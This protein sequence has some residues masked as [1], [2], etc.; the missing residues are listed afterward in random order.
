MGLQT[1]S[2]KANRQR[3]P[4]KTT[5]CDEERERGKEME[6]KL[7]MAQT[8]SNWNFSS[9]FSELS[10][11]L[12]KENEKRGVGSV[13]TWSFSAR[14]SNFCNVFMLKFR[15]LRVREWEKGCNL[16]LTFFYPL[17]Y[18]IKFN[19]TRACLNRLKWLFRRLKIERGGQGQRPEMS[20]F[21]SCYII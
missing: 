10:E 14:S 21:S 11:T 18:A 12:G 16:E 19:D 5:V 3:W 6:R 7:G 2:N 17:H 20:Y 4:L 9:R 15:L 13:L 8:L 1:P